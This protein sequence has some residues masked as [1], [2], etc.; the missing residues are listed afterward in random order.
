MG[1]SKGI[2][3]RGVAMTEEVK[4]GRIKPEDWPEDLY[5]ESGTYKQKNGKPRIDPEGQGYPGQH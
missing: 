5:W 4:K 3:T 1:H 2:E